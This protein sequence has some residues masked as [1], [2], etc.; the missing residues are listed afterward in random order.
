MRGE[1]VMKNKTKVVVFPLALSV[2]MGGYMLHKETQF[3][4]ALEKPVIITREE[5]IVIGNYQILKSQI[6]TPSTEESKE[7]IINYIASLKGDNQVVVYNAESYLIETMKQDKKLKEQIIQDQSYS[8]EIFV[9]ALKQNPMVQIYYCGSK[10]GQVEEDA[11]ALLYPNVTYVKYKES[12]DNKIK[13]HYRTNQVHSYCIQQF[14]KGKNTIESFDLEKTI[15]AIQKQYH[16]IDKQE[17]INGLNEFCDYVEN[18]TIFQK[19]E[20]AS[21]KASE[22]LE[23]YVKQAIPKIENAWDHAKPYMDHGI[24]KATGLYEE[25]KP[26]LEDAYQDAKKYVKSIFE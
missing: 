1:I 3:R 19:C 22:T 13:H 15:S 21:N 6:V 7:E 26:K 10:K 11:L 4:K 24:Q 9:E 20:E 5:E 17:V 18:T 8:E 2:L 14:R 23:P 16:D 12:I 25:A